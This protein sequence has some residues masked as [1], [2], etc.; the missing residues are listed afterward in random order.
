MRSYEYTVSCSSSYIGTTS[1]TPHPVGPKSCPQ[2]SIPVHAKKRTNERTKNSSPVHAEP[3][4]QSRMT[5]Y[6]LCVKSTYKFLAVDYHYGNCFTRR[7]FTF[8]MGTRIIFSSNVSYYVTRW[9]YEL[10]PW[11]LWALVIISPTM[12]LDTPES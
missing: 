10:G 5:R 4:V 11:I 9:K 1:K 8:S 2:N 3:Y 12:V 6:L 7:L